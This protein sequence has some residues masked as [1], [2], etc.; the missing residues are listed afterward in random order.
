VN[1]SVVTRTNG[2][3]APGSVVPSKDLGERVFVNNLDGFALAAA[4]QSQAAAATTNG[5][6][7]WKLISPALHLDAAQAPLV[8]SELGAASRKTIFAYGGGQAVDVTTNGGATWYRAL[9]QGLVE[10]MASNVQG[11]LVVFEQLQS[12]SPVR[13]YVSKNGGRTWTLTTA[14]FGG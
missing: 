12:G 13:E 4:T 9:F 14:L 6:K 8:V 7:T 2:T 10:S 1:G 11:H 5:G 3:P